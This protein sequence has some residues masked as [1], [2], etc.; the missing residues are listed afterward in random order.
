M[1]QEK[2]FKFDIHKIANEFISGKVSCSLLLFC[3]KRTFNSQIITILAVR[4][5]AGITFFSLRN[6]S[7]PHGK[8]HDRYFH[9]S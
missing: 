1:Y 5:L 2:I 6:E 8:I 9:V 7:S 4:N 3:T